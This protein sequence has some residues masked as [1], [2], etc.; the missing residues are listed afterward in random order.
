MTGLNQAHY[1]VKQHHMAMSLADYSCETN[2]LAGS[3]D[4][5][6]LC[7]Q[8]GHQAFSEA[9]SHRLVKGRECPT[10][11]FIDELPK[12]FVDPPE[13][14][15]DIKF[16]GTKATLEFRKF[17][18]EYRL[19]CHTEAGNRPPPIMEGDRLTETLTDNGKR[20]IFES[21][22]YVQALRGGYTTLLTLTMDSMA[23]CRI[24]DQEAS[25]PFCLLSRKAH[26]ECQLNEFKGIKKNIAQG[27]FSVIPWLDIT[28]NQHLKGVSIQREVSRFFDAAQKM[29]QRGWQYEQDG[30]FNWIN[31]RPRG[32]LSGKNKYCPLPLPPLIKNPPHELM[33]PAIEL[34]TVD[35]KKYGRRVMHCM[36]YR[37]VA[38]PEK[39]DYMWVVEIPDNDEGERNPHV[40]VMMRWRVD[41]NHFDAWA[42]RL[43]KLWGHGFATLDLIRHADAA[44]CYMVKAA[45]YLAKGE[46]QG[47]VRGNRYGISASARAESWTL[48]DEWE[49]GLMG[50][51][52]REVYDRV[53][54]K[55]GDLFNKRAELKAE[56]ERYRENKQKPP[57]TIAYQLNNIRK[58][59]SELKCAASKY[60]LIIKGKGTFNKFMGWMVASGYRPR[61]RPDSIWLANAKRLINESKWRRAAMTDH[62]LMSLAEANEI[63]ADNWEILK[64]DINQLYDFDGWTYLDND[65]WRD[66][67]AA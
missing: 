51:I 10:R 66:A 55:Y 63:R 31:Q 48:V 6:F 61:K 32:A 49:L 50:T 37:P 65:S 4:L 36:D 19:R 57:A 52:I 64:G 58:N 60:Q 14:V 30:P 39:L 3:E 8:S 17:C 59:L 34:Q 16:A 67:M 15:P 11:V 56:R 21:A 7:P 20:K 33:G 25:G 26:T 46:D 43:E 38:L 13:V 35:R 27:E 24:G 1:D 62:D 40:H 42:V 53:T 29:Y 18:D 22:Q 41:R 28:H 9:D 47:V 44:G 12:V 5:V 23:R 45:G 2:S 54:H